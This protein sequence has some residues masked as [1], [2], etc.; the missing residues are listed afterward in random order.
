ML[1][2]RVVRVALIG[3]AVLVAGWLVVRQVA[4]SSDPVS[5]RE[6][7]A[8]FTTAARGTV[9]TGGPVPGVYRYRATGTERGGAGPLVVSRGLPA[10]AR[11]VV[12]AHDG[13][14]QAEVSYS[15]QHIEG[16]R[17]VL[18]DGAI[19]V[20]WRR[21]KVTFAGFGRDDR[22]SVTPPSVFLPVRPE[23]GANWVEEYRTGDISVRAESRILRRE[24]MT[25]AGERLE[26]LVL[27]SRSTT[28]GAHPG[29]RTET[30][31]WSPAL[32]LPVRWNVDMD[33]GG[34]FA[35]KARSSLVLRATAPV[36]SADP[37]PGD[38]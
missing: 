17:Y 15:R 20:T 13:G 19:R 25:V 27:E 34:V 12:T 22:R 14:W 7:L 37:P 18:R 10:E 5:D 1:R 31:W 32:G 36:T 11:L 23:V 2:S 9:P 29:I 4:G 24:R 30:L 26:T 3:V 21:T 38:R 33:I 6:A 8:T 28:S 35:F 16:A